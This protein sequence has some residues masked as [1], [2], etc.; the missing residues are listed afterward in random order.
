A[1]NHHLC[2]RW[3]KDRGMGSK[4][5]DRM[6]CSLSWTW[7][8]DL[9]ACGEKI[10]VCLFASHELFLLGSFGYAGRSPATWYHKDIQQNFVDTHGQSE[11]AFAFCHLLGFQLMP[12][13]KNIG[14]QKLSPPESGATD[15]YPNLE[16]VLARP[17]KWDLIR[18]QYDQMMKYATALR[19]GTAD[20]ESIL[21]RFRKNPSHPTYQAL[22]ELGK[23]VKTMFLCQYL[24]SEPVRHDVEEGL[25]TTENWNSAMGFIFFGRSGEITNNQPEEM[26]IVVL[27]LHLLQNSLVYIDTLQ[28]Q[29]LMQEKQWMSHMSSQDF[30]ALTP[31]I[32][33]HVN[34]Y[35]DFQVDLN[36]RL[37][38]SGGS[39]TVEETTRT[40]PT[41]KAKQLTK[42]LRSE[43]ADYG[44]LKSV[45]RHLRIE[46]EAE[47]PRAPKKLPYVPTE[48]EIE[49]Y[50]DVVW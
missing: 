21:R 47:V 16:P 12:R 27:C 10:H 38:V 28:I 43:R 35:G 46:L 48:K 26:E 2:F 20:A 40:S 19:L 39:I 25:N 42:Y 18:K 31:L 6:A 45:F 49:R 14:S 34:P 24:H 44:Y 8:Y 30:R 15:L 3:Q 37:T 17:I 36:K 4:L 7:H 22:H 32:Y 29:Q 9:L 23:V 11:V 33:N 13:F 41:K 1:I 50:Y 5:I